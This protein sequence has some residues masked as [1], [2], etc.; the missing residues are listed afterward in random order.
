[1][2]HTSK[3]R[4]VVLDE[5]PVLV[6]GL[7]FLINSARPLAA[8][9]IPQRD[10]KLCDHIKRQH[11]DV[12]VA[13]PAYLERALTAENLDFQSFRGES[14][15]IAYC[16]VRETQPA[17]TYINRGYN[18]V[19]TKTVAS[20]RLLRAIKAVYAGD[21]VIDQS[22][23]AVAERIAPEIEITRGKLSGKEA[24]VLR[25]VALGKAMKE[26]AADIQLSA[27]TVE[28]YKYRAIKKLDLRTR[29][30]IVNYAISVGWL[31]H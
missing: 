9:V 31:Q 15:L 11:P 13:D 20:P 26:I 17:E 7:N 19:V 30:D 23:L 25:H 8:L 18:G 10:L 14:R 3:I 22:A 24:F 4:V 12:I 29:S 27:K 6:D 1:M 5:N 2:D 28:T 21:V 16:D